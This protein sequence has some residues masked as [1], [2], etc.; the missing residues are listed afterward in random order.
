[1]ETINRVLEELLTAGRIREGYLGVGMQPIPI[2]AGLREKTGFGSESGLIVLN[3]VAG[4]PAEES[5]LQL[6]DILVAL[7]DKPITDVEELQAVLRGEN[8]DRTL[9]AV[10]IRGGEAVRTAI[11]V[12]ERPRKAN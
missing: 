12:T 7:D 5:G 11:K 9:N 8:V 10:L 2:P 3:V 6:G 4:S 1:V